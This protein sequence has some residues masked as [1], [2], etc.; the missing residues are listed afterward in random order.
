MFRIDD[1]ETLIDC[2]HGRL[3]RSCPQSIANFVVDDECTPNAMASGVCKRRGLFQR[4]AKADGGAGTVFALQPHGAAM[5]LHKLLA[6]GKS[7]TTASLSPACRNVGLLEGFEDSLL[8]SGGNAWARVRYADHDVCVF[9]STMEVDPTALR[10]APC[11]A[12]QIDDDLANA[13]FVTVDRRQVR[14]NL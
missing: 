5:H 10:K 13:R 7:E 12:Q 6:D 9:L 11:V 3:G 2:D 8:I 1:Y 14:C 4:E